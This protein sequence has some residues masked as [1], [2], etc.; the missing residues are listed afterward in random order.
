[1]IALYN[2]TITLFN[3]Y[4]NRDGDTWYPTVIRGVNLNI[5]RAAIVAKYGA[6]SSDSAVLNV[7][8]LLDGGNKIIVGKPWRAPKAWEEQPNDELGCSLTFKGGSTFD[9]FYVGEWQGTEPIADA[10]YSG[11]F[12]TYMNDRY[13]NVFAITSVGMYSVIPHFEILGK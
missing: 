2:D 4:T 6:Q 10:E 11:G 9:F 7:G 12:Y 3:R 8:Y 5:D 1:M 13:D